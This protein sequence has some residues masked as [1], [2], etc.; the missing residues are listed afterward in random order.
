MA[1]TLDGSFGHT[2]CNPICAQLGL[3]EFKRYHRASYSPLSDWGS[4]TLTRA[5]DKLQLK[6]APRLVR[7]DVSVSIGT[8]TVL[9]ASSSSS[10]SNSHVPMST[11][12]TADLRD[13]LPST[14][15]LEATISDVPALD[16]D[17][18]DDGTEQERSEGALREGLV[19]QQLAVFFESGRLSEDQGLADLRA[20]FFHYQQAASLNVLSALFGLA[21]VYSGLPRSIL[22]E[23]SLAS[24]ENCFRCLLHAAKLYRHPYA[25]FLVAGMYQDGR[26]VPAN[27]VEALRWYDE[28]VSFLYSDKPIP[29]SAGHETQID[30]H[31]FDI[32]LEKHD[33]LQRI[34]KIYELGGDGAQIDLERAIEYYRDAAEAAM[35]AQ[36]VHHLPRLVTS[37]LADACRY[38]S[39][40]RVY[41]P[42]PAQ[43]KL[44]MQLYNKADELESSM[45]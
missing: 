12:N 31:G 41:A 8:P 32:A 16:D 29:Q 45:D 38:L 30:F 36:K 37:N 44:S 40:D 26:G 43:G 25:C 14:A 33:I 34:A 2:Q 39:L 5:F 7:T 24:D 3:S 10:T 15:S 21:R 6:S 1:D 13:L 20:A 18:D 23:L 28:L 35:E 17:D 9:I 22:S 4:T 11:S 19:H 42:L 27:K